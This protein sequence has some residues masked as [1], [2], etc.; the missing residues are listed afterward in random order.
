MHPWLD[1]CFAPWPDIHSSAVH[2]FAHYYLQ[3][4]KHPALPYTCTYYGDFTVKTSVT[5]YHSPKILDFLHKKMKLYGVNVRETA[6]QL[7]ES[8]FVNL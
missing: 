1:T 4:E 6:L 7:Q 5:S 2:V 8:S 3:D